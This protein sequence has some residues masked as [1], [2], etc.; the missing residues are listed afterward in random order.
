[1]KLETICMRKF[2][3]FRK[4]RC[5]FTLRFFIVIVTLLGSIT[6]NG[7]GPGA[8][9]EFMR[10]VNLGAPT[11][12][13]DFEVR[14]MLNGAAQH[15][16]MK[17]DGG[18]LRFY[19]AD[20]TTE[21]N[22]FLEKFDP[23]GISVIWVKVPAAG[24]NAIRMYYGNP[25]ASTTSNGY[26]TF[27][28]FDGFEGNS[29]KSDWNT[30]LSDDPGN[31]TVSGGEVTLNLPNNGKVWM[32]NNSTAQFFGLE[33]GESSTYGKEYNVEVKHSSDGFFRNRFYLTN[34]AITGTGNDKSLSGVGAHEYR[35]N[36]MIFWKGASTS[37]RLME[38]TDYITSWYFLRKNAEK[39]FRWETI[40]FSDYNTFS[41]Q[42]ST[43]NDVLV[44]RIYIG[45]T[46][47]PTKMKLDWV[48]VRKGHKNEISVTI[49]N[50]VGIGTAPSISNMSPE[51]GCEGT[52]LTLTGDF[53]TNF[54]RRVFIGSEELAVT[55]SSAN[56]ITA[57]LGSTSGKVKV[58]TSGGY[59]EST[60]AVSV[61]RL[62]VVTAGAALSEI[63]ADETTVQ[64]GGTVDFMGDPGTAGWSVAPNEGSIRGSAFADQR[65]E[66]PKTASGEYT[67]TLTA[68]NSCGSR[69]ITKPIHVNPLPPASTSITANLTEVCF[70]SAVTFTA[71]PD[72]FK[73]YNFNGAVG[74]SNF[75]NINN[76]AVGEHSI[77][78][79]ITTNKGCSE[80]FTAPEVEVIGKPTGSIEVTESSGSGPSD[81]RVCEDDQIYL[82]FTGKGYENYEFFS[83]GISISDGP[84]PTPSVSDLAPG[85][86]IIT[87]TVTDRGCPATF[88]YGKTVVVHEKPS[89]SLTGNPETLTVC[90]GSNIT[91]TATAGLSKYQFFVEDISKAESTE[92]TY[93]S[94]FTDGDEIYVLATDVNGCTATSETKT[95]TVNALP[96][97][98]TING[99]LAVCSGGTTTLSVGGSYN[100]YQWLRN[101]VVIAGETSQS[102]T[103]SN[104]TENAEYSV[105]VGNTS[106]SVTSAPVT[107]TVKTLPAVPDI[108]NTNLAFCEGDNIVLNSSIGTNIQWLLDGTPITG[109]TSQNYTAT[110]GGAYSILHTSGNGCSIESATKT[111][112]KNP[113]PDK[114][115][116]T[117]DK[118][119]AIC[120][121]ESVLLTAPA[122]FS[123][124]W[125]K[126]GDAIAGKTAQTFSATISGVY[127]LRVANTSGCFEVSDTV[128][129]IVNPLPVPQITS[130]KVCV[131]LTEYETDPGMSNYTW[132]IVR[133]EGTLLKDNENPHKA[134]VDWA[135]ESGPKEISVIYTDAN[136]CT[137]EGATSSASTTAITPII[138][139]AKEVC[140]NEETIYTTEA[141]MQGYN[142]TISG[143]TALG[144]ANSDEFTVRWDG[145]GSTRSVSVM[146]T[147]D[148]GCSAPAPTVENVVVNALPTASISGT[149]TVCQEGGSPQVKLTGGAGVA[150]YNITYNIN[151]GDAVSLSGQ[152]TYNVSHSTANDGEF[153][154]NLIS[155]EDAKGCSNDA[156]GSAMI[157]VTA[158]PL[159]AFSYGESALCNGE[160]SAVMPVFNGTGGGTFTATPAGLTIDPATGAITPSASN[161]K[162]YTVKYTVAAA[163][164][165]ATYSKE[166]TVVI[167]QKPVITGFK[168]AATTP[169]GMTEYCSSNNVTQGV[170]M[171]GE[172][173][174]GGTYSVSPAGLTLNPSTGEFNP[175]NAP[176]GTYTITYRIASSN[177]C[178]E[179]SASVDVII[180]APPTATI[181]YGIQPVCVTNT[182]INVDLSGTNAYQNG[183][184]SGTAGLAIHSATGELNPSASTVGAH[185]VTYTIPASGGCGETP[186]KT[187]VT[188]SP[189]ADVSAGS[190]FSICADQKNVAVGG[191]ASA[192]NTSSVI[193]S[194]GTGSWSNAG[195]LNS[196]A[197]TPSASEI[198][199][200]S[201]MLT[202]TGNGSAGCADEQTTAAK[203]ITINNL[204]QPVVINPV[205]AENCVGGVQ[206]L[207]SVLSNV[208]EGSKEAA[209]TG[210]IVAIPDN[211]DNGIFKTLAVSGIPGNAVIYKIDLEFNID[212]ESNTDLTVNLKAPNGNVL[213]IVNALT[214]EGF[215]GTK[216]SS[217][218]TNLIHTSGDTGPFT[219]T[220]GPQKR[221]GTQGAKS[222]PGNRAFAREFDE[223]YSV[224][225][226]DWILS[227]RDGGLGDVGSFK[228]WSIKIYYKI[229]LDQI[230][231]LWSPFTDLFLDADAKTP[232]NG[233]ITAVV[234]AKSADE[235]SFTY[236][237]T[238]TDE[239]ACASNK[240]VTLVVKP[241]PNVFIVADY[242]AKA[243]EG[244]IQLTA[245]APG[246]ISYNWNTGETTQS[247]L[248]DIANEYYVTVANSQG[249]TST[250]IISV[251]E[252]LVE[253]GDFELGNVGFRTEY[254][255]T[256]APNGMIPEGTYAVDTSANYYH[257]QFH[258]RDHTTTEQTGNFLI[259][260]GAKNKI[261][262]PP[263]HRVIW[264]Q[265]VDVLPN[266]DYYF[267]AW[268]MN[269]NGP[270]TAELQFSINGELVGKIAYLRNVAI[271]ADESQIDINNWVR[272]YSDPKWNSDTATSAVIQIVNLNPQGGGNDIGLDDISFGTLQPFISGPEITGRDDQTVC[273]DEDILSIRYKVGSGDVPK[274]V[275][276]INGL[277]DE[278]DGYN[279]T[280][281]GNI[282]TPGVYNYTVT[283]TGSCANPFTVDG[284]VTVIDNSFISLSPGNSGDRTICMNSNLTDAIKYT[285]GGTAESAVFEG[286]PPGMVGSVTPENKVLI[287][288]AAIEEGT[289][290]YTVTAK[291]KC[292]DATINGVIKIDGLSNAGTLEPPTVCL[293]ES[294][295]V[296]LSDYT[297][298]IIGWEMSDDGENFSLLPN[299]TDQQSFSNITQP[300]YYRVT[301]KNGVCENDVS[302]VR[303]V[304]IRNLWE[305]RFSHDWKTGQ[306][307]SAGTEPV[308]N[309]L[310][311]CNLNTTIPKVIAGND[312]PVLTGII[313]GA[314]H[315]LNILTGG[316]L[317]IAGEGVLKISGAINNQGLLDASDGGL[318]F[319]GA[320][321]QTLSGSILKD[322]TVK[323]L[324]LNNPVAFNISN[325]TG[326]TLNITGMLSFVRSNAKINTGD[327]VTLKSTHAATASVGAV[328]GPNN[329]T[330]KFVVE[331]FINTGVKGVHY[332][333]SHGKS[334]Q[335]LSTPVKNVSIRDSWQEGVI[336]TGVAANQ[337]IAN[338]NHGYGTLL[339][340]GRNNV[341]ANGFDVYTQPGPSMKAYVAS[342]DTW[343]AGPV[344]TTDPLYNEKGYLVM[345]R[346][347][348]SVY[349]YNQ[350]ATPTVL[351]AKGN[352]ITGNTTPITVK[353]GQFA[354]VGNPYP[355]SVKIADITRTGG[356]DDFI[357]VWDPTLN[358]D[359]GLGA[360]VTLTPAITPGFYEAVPAAGLYKDPVS[361]IQSGQAFFVQATGSDGTVSF[362]ESAKSSESRL[363]MRGG[364]EAERSSALRIN[365]YNGNEKIIDGIKLSL[366]ERFSNEVDGKDAR[367][368]LNNSE[369]LA[370]RLGQELLV[371]ESRK[372]FSQSDTLFLD[373]TGA[374]A[375]R[376]RFEFDPAGLEKS[377]LQPYLEDTY[378]NT[379]TPFSF[380]DKSFHDFSIENVPGSYAA[381]RF[382]IVFRQ[383]AALPVTLLNLK[384]TARQD[385][386][387]QVSWNVENPV[388]T[389]LY[390]VERSFDGQNFGH[391]YKIEAGTG[392][393]KFVW[394]DE[395]VTDGTRYYRVKAVDRDGRVTLSD[396]VKVSLHTD[397]QI[398]IF[399][400]PIVNRTVQV[401]FSN[402]Q[403]GDYLIRV[404][405][406]L[407]RISFAKEVKHEGGN[408]KYKLPWNYKMARGIYQIEVRKPNAEVK[409]FKVKY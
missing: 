330:G 251:A 405:D 37:Q 235:G 278:W 99:D 224:P 366:N 43:Y 363:M 87:A 98:P 376:Y 373:L 151:G 243:P 276:D 279:Y 160:T 372:P 286:L 317:T 356:V 116:I 30:S 67:L 126:D 61:F 59:T 173:Y 306:N 153:L 196:A 301:V 322:K 48:R 338:P 320:S 73:T 6:V 393:Q 326:D 284:K 197:Y 385:N 402:L 81:N 147:D 283:T 351:R 327:N 170:I 294:G 42:T 331:R 200:G 20:G 214:G 350:A 204:P 172:N 158:K 270:A 378:K 124:Q 51:S 13:I 370:V 232:Y 266:T 387:V 282:S 35:E 382:R 250:G 349:A 149:A 262:N 22:Y 227:V 138:T 174:G 211:N 148:E 239:N 260:N 394:M 249:C 257:P 55:S 32:Y 313:P 93:Q 219:G 230:P 24:E 312:D 289:Y 367:K 353:A 94:A 184:F 388:N 69:I 399:P 106:C 9:W 216:I 256:N 135:N 298:E 323:N 14:I 343:D 26:N 228:N 161:V 76:L 272:F 293:G 163:G 404:I 117:K 90:E 364:I 91:F 110:E 60:S 302:E 259:I 244:K 146:Y 274:L 120:E 319:N 280:L 39:T 315:N 358:G 165:C 203:V 49:E 348:R 65:W 17:S 360:Y 386:G 143:G 88:T 304:R 380:T 264:E 140:Q 273:V 287:T 397:S 381:N 109:A 258:G 104:V 112:S 86:H 133:G 89:V 169:D 78:V 220:Y 408:Q 341:P 5:A 68:T 1:M 248:V 365:L 247:V 398:S 218:S 392:S 38:N 193:W 377:N 175:Y 16:H 361:D 18:D 183:I 205:S 238:S 75:A 210:G 269:L 208:T 213:N 4:E 245:Q 329:I 229:P 337:P 177:G 209:S 74:N 316:H 62:P 223:L 150:P 178:D 33:E 231:V 192:Q 44:D 182:G 389:S 52:T 334:W 3:S 391:T 409:I 288:G 144:G 407:G 328:P 122:G 190:D 318:E 309:P 179:V 290:N 384:A 383:T 362:K 164:G 217:E 308:L 255:Y 295:V 83:N 226:G 157:T 176:A 321:T 10:T 181:G 102:L 28:Y 265:T 396:V 162:S 107:V 50:E 82:A 332:G 108:T 40:R 325:S 342:T 23:A 277:Q 237:A 156:T 25:G 233:E 271:P 77:P 254:T 311:G 29:L 186:V 125:I 145:T 142:W 340:T 96:E 189:M 70:G 339:T 297:G 21:L 31:I 310:S 314:V 57:T 268:A 118:N 113:K 400:N 15:A 185:T 134:I 139:G 281:K 128:Q 46:E 406:P 379:K 324:R 303:G 171:E 12:A 336:S 292:K 101:G 347:D 103:I 195:N 375:A 246:T 368:M 299:T 19:S 390:I 333:D 346:G 121:N 187:N 34:Y 240:D 45:L 201:V 111:V 132:N 53:A 357:T 296:K 54:E 359:Y 66:I 159:A 80:T 206:P 207:I 123:Y 85:N 115:V 275:N 221:F 215:T 198:T 64:L 11:P 300:T 352:I 252:E 344:S 236:T 395:D 401:I 119:A 92:N 56:T 403:K 130:G 222:V 242:C 202:L 2:Y 141:G 369:N 225:N 307:W 253:N 36:G 305:G 152:T 84:S 114:P 374:R 261:G 355:S 285:L 79:I 191:G 105:T 129:V 371:M 168:Y 72:T 354:S 136:G 267:S 8:G 180:T 234:Y 194:G 41:S 167:S 155:V 137:S 188:I 7:Q 154:Y 291:G 58:I 95:V 63:C 212:H 97:T 100:S 166:T 27:L 131:G 47:K 335:L 263:R 199:N 71:T 127:T 241:S 345:V